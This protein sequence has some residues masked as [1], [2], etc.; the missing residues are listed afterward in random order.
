MTK[1]ET[2]D[3]KGYFINDLLQ[4]YGFQSYLELG[5]CTGETWNN[6]NCEKKIGVDYNSGIQIENVVNLTTDDYF[7]NLSSD[8]KFDCIFI[9][10]CHEKTQVKRD[11]LNSFMHLNANGI[12][13]L[14]DINSWTKEGT[15]L[16][17]HGDCYEFWLSLVDKYDDHCQTFCNEVIGD[18]VGLFFK[19]SLNSIDETNFED[20]N[21]GYKFLVDNR[22]KYLFS[23]KYSI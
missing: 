14:H 22:E 16:T 2:E 3:W 13:V 20:M 9:D 11:F 4:K 17:A 12:I 21:Y 15:K 19:K 10:A 6:V 1:Y 18:Y 5:V 23:K 8:V 7:L